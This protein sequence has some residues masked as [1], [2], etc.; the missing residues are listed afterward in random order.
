MP[1]DTSGIWRR[2]EVPARRGPLLPSSTR[3]SINVS[4]IGTL[5]PLRM[6]TPIFKVSIDGARRRHGM[7]SGSVTYSSF[8]TSSPFCGRL[9]NAKKM[10]TM[11]MTRKRRRLLV[12]AGVCGNC[13]NAFRMSQPR[14]FSRG[15]LGW[16]SWESRVKAS[17]RCCT[18]TTG[19]C[20]APRIGSPLQRRADAVLCSSRR[21]G[22]GGGPAEG[23]LLRYLRSRLPGFGV[24]DVRV[25]EV[26][27]SSQYYGCWTDL[28]KFV[29]T[30]NARIFKGTLALLASQR[31]LDRFIVTARPGGIPA[32]G[33]GSGWVHVELL[34]FSDLQ[35]QEALAKA[36]R[37][38]VRR[39]DNLELDPEDMDRRL[40][41]DSGLRQVRGNALLLTMAVLFY[42]HKSPSPRSIV[43]NST[44]AQSARCV[45]RGS[46]T[47]WR[48]RLKR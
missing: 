48:T 37:E 20:T 16:W 1:S 29:V 38:V 28:M 40:V 3:L 44:K 41:A 39:K 8:R 31:T 18:S 30:P 45:M 46:D 12:N 24:T 13:S 17:Q 9:P 25:I 19:F 47:S 21:V 26:S 23:R 36:G 35:V 7:K 6:A 22:S 43:G 15:P 10:K 34:E 27:S 14:D 11:R 2:R 33:L 5:W 32:G 4:N 42:R